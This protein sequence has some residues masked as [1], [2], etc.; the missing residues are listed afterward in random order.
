[1][2]SELEKECEKMDVRPKIL[3]EATEME[4]GIGK[5]G[6]L[7]IFFNHFLVCLCVSTS[8]WCIWYNGTHRHRGR[9]CISRLIACSAPE[10]S[11]IR[12]MSVKECQAH[13]KRQ[14]DPYLK[15]RN[16]T[17]TSFAASIIFF[18]CVISL[19]ESAFALYTVRV[20]CRD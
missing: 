12:D 18:P 4:G 11:C 8:S 16:F 20:T 7:Q 1:M 19:G 9:L 3:R 17:P 14:V 15:T 10:E 5:T 13:R 2:G 6:C